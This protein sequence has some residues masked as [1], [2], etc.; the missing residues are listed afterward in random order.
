MQSVV[1]TH[2]NVRRVIVITII[3]ILII[4]FLFLL[5]VYYTSDFCVE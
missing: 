2:E 4:I 5:A 3:I 1:N